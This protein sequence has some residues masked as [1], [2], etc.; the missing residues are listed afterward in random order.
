MAFLFVVV[1]FKLLTQAYQPVEDRVQL[2]EILLEYLEEYNIQ[3]P[4][5]MHLVFFADAVAHV[6]RI[7]RV[8]RQPRGNA[9][10]VGVGG[11]DF[12]R[13]R[14]MVVLYGHIPPHESHAMYV[15][16]PWC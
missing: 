2:G 13:S 3:F 12:A 1:F 15:E 14:S 11:E 8:L 16:T 6:S 9:L 5:Q 4:S 7:C 10:L